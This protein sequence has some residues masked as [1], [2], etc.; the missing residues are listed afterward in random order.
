MSL[1]L[2]L[3]CTIRDDGYYTAW[4][5]DKKVVDEYIEAINGLPVDY[6]E[7]GYRNNPQNEYLGK[8]GYCPVYELIEIRKKSS[9]HRRDVIYH[10]F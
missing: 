10:F 2:L 6:I 8:Y 4:D 7:I 9:L 5:F 1:P 3:D